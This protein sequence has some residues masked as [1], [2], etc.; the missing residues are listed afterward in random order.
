MA[1]KNREQRRHEK[2]GGG[3]ANEA[4]VW[5]TSRPN[6]VFGEPADSADA[7]VGIPDQEESAKAAPAPRKVPATKTSAKRSGT[8]NSSPK[9]SRAK[10]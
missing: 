8:A 5:P 3:R 7:A 10:G 9:G 1:K 2:F 6:P 4:G